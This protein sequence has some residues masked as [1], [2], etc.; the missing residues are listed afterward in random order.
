NP[1]Q[2]WPPI[3]W[4]PLAPGGLAGI[5]GPPG[6]PPRVA[7][8]VANPPPPLPPVDLPPLSHVHV[9]A[10]PGEVKNA[11]PPLSEKAAFPA[12]APLAPSA[13]LLPFP[14]VTLQRWSVTALEDTALMAMLLAPASA[15]SALA[16]SKSVRRT[17]PST[18]VIATA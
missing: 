1:V 10:S 13:P 11:L 12:P 9:F 18:F 3:P 15:A 7:S 17:A 6:K 14:A 2:V 16:I 4:R 5:D 8:P